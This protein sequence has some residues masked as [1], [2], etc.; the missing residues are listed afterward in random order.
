MKLDPFVPSS[1]YDTGTFTKIL[2]LPIPLFFI[3]PASSHLRMNHL[4]GIEIERFDDVLI[5]AALFTK[6][7]VVQVIL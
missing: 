4:L 6:R 3:I 2:M 5:V 1:D 7:I